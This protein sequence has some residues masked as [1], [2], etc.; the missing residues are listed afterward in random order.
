LEFRGHRCALWCLPALNGKRGNAE[1]AQSTWEG[2]RIAL[3]GFGT[4]YASLSHLR[5]QMLGKLK[6]DQVF[7]DGQQSE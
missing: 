3:D 4:T 2:L 7:K 1:P 5:R 6:I